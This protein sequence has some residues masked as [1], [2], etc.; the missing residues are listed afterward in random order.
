MKSIQ[1]DKSTLY[2]IIYKGGFKEGA[3][4]LKHALFHVFLLKLNKR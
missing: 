3:W 1:R 4:E 2:I